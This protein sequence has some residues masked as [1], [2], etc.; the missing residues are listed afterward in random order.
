[1]GVR[2]LHEPTRTAVAAA[3]IVSRTAVSEALIDAWGGGNVRARI[4]GPGDEHTRTLTLGPFTIES[5]DRRGVIPGAIAADAPV[6]PTVPGSP[7]IAALRWEFRLLD[8]TPIFDTDEIALGAIKALCTPRLSGGSAAVAF[9]PPQSL[10][11][12]SFPAW[13]PATVGTAALVPMTNTLESVWTTGTFANGK[14]SAALAD[15]SGGVYNPYIGE[16]GIFTVHGAGHAANNDNG[17]YSAN[18]SAL[19]WQLDFSATELNALG[20]WVDY[21]GTANETGVLATS[22]DYFTVFGPESTNW[23]NPLETSGRQFPSGATV[24]S[25]G[26]C[27]TLPG[28]PGSAHTYQTMI[29]QPPSLG[30]GPH[31]SLLRLTSAAVASRASRDN[32]WVHRYDY[33]AGTW[34]RYGT[35]SAA[36][37]APGATA[38]LDTSRGK[39]HLLNPPQYTVGTVCIFDLATATWTNTAA[40]VPGVSGYID[41]SIGAYH[42]ARDI[43]VQATCPNPATESTPALF[44]WHAGSSNISTRAAVSWTGSAPRH[45]N[46]GQGALVY[47]PNGQLFYYTQYNANQYYLIDVPSNPADAWTATAFDI[48]GTLPSSFSPVAAGAIYGRMDYCAAAKSILWLTGQGGG[49]VH[50]G[51]RVWALRIVP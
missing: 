37:A 17:V 19:A 14:G 9:V 26:G 39:A 6:A 45:F 24:T 35:N 43:I 2:I 50:F 15:Y 49:Q 25:A 1:M 47:L 33:D 3:T 46:F 16:Y 5:A 41:N 13:A 27:E 48:S 36:W 32:A 44:Y 7:G 8:E 10:P 18:L 34:S 28:V 23:S 30:G 20:K 22:Y 29:L 42:A 40:S 31:G 21:Q 4:Y 11:V 38:V 51:G 12:T